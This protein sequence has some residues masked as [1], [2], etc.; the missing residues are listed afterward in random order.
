[1]LD[2]LF[3]WITKP[4]YMHTPLDTLIILIEVVVIII[5]FTI[6]AGRD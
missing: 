4:M 5:L 2:I 3:G 6:W 1:M